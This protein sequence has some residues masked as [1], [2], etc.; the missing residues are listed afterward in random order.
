MHQLFGGLRFAVMVL[1]PE[2]VFRYRCPALKPYSSNFHAASAH[3]HTRAC[4][5]E[6]DSFVRIDIV[7]SR[8]ATNDFNVLLFAVD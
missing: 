7:V 1:Q 3:A 5:T 8:A 6:L 2:H 4:C